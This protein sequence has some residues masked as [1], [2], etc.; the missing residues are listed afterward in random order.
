M[1]RVLRVRTACYAQL[2]GR[3]GDRVINGDLFRSDTLI[4]FI[5]K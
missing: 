5:G 3:A 1:V 2:P 4:C